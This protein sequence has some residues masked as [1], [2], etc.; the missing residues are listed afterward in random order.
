MT[1]TWRP[2]ALRPQYDPTPFRFRGS[3]VEN[4]WRKASALAEPDGVT[5]RLWPDDAEYPRWSMPGLEAG[6]AAQKQ[7]AELGED[8]FLRFHTGLYRAFFIDNQSPLDKDTAL[9]VARQVGLDTNAFL[10]DL[11]DETFRASVRAQ[12]Q[13]VVDA[14]FV[15]AV[16]TVLIG[17]SPSGEPAAGASRHIGLVPAEDYVRDL[18]KILGTRPADTHA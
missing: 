2:F 6:A 11:E 13:D 7:A 18:E 12:C 8:A 17:V 5:Y 3:Y 16:P 10:R 14:F 4:A 1:V 15:S 9:A